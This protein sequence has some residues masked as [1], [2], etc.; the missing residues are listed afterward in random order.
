MART[1]NYFGVNQNRF[2]AA[3]IMSGASPQLCTVYACF[4]Y[5]KPNVFKTT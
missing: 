4:M 5:V 2:K 3:K 1:L